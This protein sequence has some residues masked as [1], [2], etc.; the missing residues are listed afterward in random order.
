MHTQIDRDEIKFWLS[1][2]KHNTHSETL[3]NSATKLGI[4][5]QALPA[6]RT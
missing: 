2:L 4:H 6:L 3:I 1:V 5:L